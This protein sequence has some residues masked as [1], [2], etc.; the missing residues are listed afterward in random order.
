[1]SELPWRTLAQKRPELGAK[2]FIAVKAEGNDHGLDNTKLEPFRKGTK[3]EPF[4]KGTN[5]S[6][7]GRDVTSWGDREGFFVKS[8]GAAPSVAEEAT[9]PPSGEIKKE[10]ELHSSSPPRFLRGPRLVFKPI[11]WAR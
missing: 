2:R 5:L 3:L 11:V 8:R 1:M 9:S 4:R 6:P 10:A 7:C